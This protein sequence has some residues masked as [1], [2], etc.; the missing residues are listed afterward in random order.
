MD[1]RIWKLKDLLVAAGEPPLTAYT[2][3]N[4]SGDFILL[5]KQQIPIPPCAVGTMF[6]IFQLGEHRGLPKWL[7]IDKRRCC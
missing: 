7:S 3:D 1:E 6:H 5:L 2:T 4:D